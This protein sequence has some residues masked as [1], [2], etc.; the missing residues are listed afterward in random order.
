MTTSA[1]PESG[2]GPVRDDMI[3]GS[4]PSGYTAAVYA[5]RAG[6]KPLGG[7]PMSAT[8]TVT[9]AG[10]AT[11]VEASQLPVLVDVWATWCAPCRQIAPI[12]EDL[13]EVYAGRL[14]IAKLDADANPATVT[15][16]GVTSIPTLAF[17][18]G[19]APVHTLVGAQP[20]SAI[21]AAIE[22]VLA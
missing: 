11:M 18:S 12:L 14:T 10:F 8:T 20:R 17:Y 19:G 9:D 15:A 21:L 16:L 3:T 5:A 13:V 2:D 7:L 4:G 22:E 1:A 6:L